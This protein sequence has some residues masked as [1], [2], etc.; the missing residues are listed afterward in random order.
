MEDLWVGIWKQELRQRP[1][2]HAPS[3]KLLWFCSVCFRVYPRA[4]PY[5]LLTCL[6][7]N[8]MDAFFPSRS[9][10]YPEGPDPCQ[11]DGNLTFYKINSLLLE[12]FVC[13]IHFLCFSLAVDI[14][15]L[16]QGIT[17][18]PKLTSDWQSSCLS[19]LTTG[20]VS[21][22]HHTHSKS[23]HFSKS[24]TTLETICLSLTQ[25]VQGEIQYFLEFVDGLGNF[26]GLSAPILCFLFYD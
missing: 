3:G 10:C 14:V 20:I 12:P 18:Y 17:V 9:P 25:W 24:P 8:L 6:W 1:L 21:V 4:L 23:F 26:L 5:Q 7:V 11:L 22:N 13:F 16:R 2:K 15:V 19:F